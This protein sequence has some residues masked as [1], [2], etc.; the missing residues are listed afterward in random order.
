MTQE[1]FETGKT[2][3]VS[4]AACN[5]DLVVKSWAD[6][7]VLVKGDQYEANQTEAALSIV[8]RDKLQLWLP[9]GATLAVEQ[10]KGD[11]VIKHVVGDLSI[12]EV[13]GDVVLVGLGQVKIQTVHGDL[14]AKNI[15]GHLGAGVVHGDTAV[16]GVHTLSLNTVHGDCAIR[17]VNGGVQLGEVAGD[18][19]VRTVNEAV[20]I[21]HC[22]RDV[23]LQNLGG[24]VTV[25]RAEGDVRLH[26][27]LSATDHAIMAEG[28]IVL[29]WPLDAPLN[30]VANSSRIANRLPLD[31][32]VEGQDNLTGR[33]GDGGTNLTL[34][35]NGRI[36]LKEADMVREE[37]EQDR[38]EAMEF[39]FA[40]DFDKL[41]K[42]INE[43]VSRVTAELENK[44]RTRFGPDF[45]SEMA[46]KIA[47]KTEMAAAKAEQAAEKIRRQAEG[48][49]SKMYYR[50]DGPR[51]PAPPTP[52][53]PPAAK[54][55]KA[56]SEEQLKILQMVEKGV[57]SP[58][59]AATLLE[60]LEN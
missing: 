56:S 47:R 54:K 57:I 15:E 35:A 7:A 8:S 12:G 28:D 1:R 32:A 13:E 58:V 38:A 4:V 11:L 27:G 55:K 39:D 44:I 6:S 16:R 46:E 34:T 33:I 25:D 49:S 17:F 37:W 14:S 31:K 48:R 60:A 5:G 40:F 19:A 41:A 53:A 36:I 21:S 59:E 45:T 23:N 43:K 51:P 2:P 52:P 29:R 26:G 10:T 42:Q 9:T 3:Q 22:H 30:L 18:I 50:S 24:Q 20:K